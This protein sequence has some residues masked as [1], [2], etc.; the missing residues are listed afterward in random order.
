MQN[1]QFLSLKRNGN[2]TLR[3]EH[4]TIPDEKH[5]PIISLTDGH[6]SCKHLFAREWERIKRKLGQIKS[7]KPIQCS[8]L[9]KKNAKA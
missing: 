2:Y 7:S 6:N 5:N 8:K 1:Q 9:K 3:N 4:A